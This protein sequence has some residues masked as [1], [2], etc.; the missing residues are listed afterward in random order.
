MT[1]PVHRFTFDTPD[2]ALLF[3]RQVFATCFDVVSFRDGCTVLVIDGHK[4]P[5]TERLL[6]LA[7]GLGSVPPGSPI[8]PPPLPFDRP[9]RVPTNPGDEAIDV[10]LVEV[11]DDWSDPTKPAKPED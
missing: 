2:R 8:P 7:R 11:D 10:D 4:P 6:S 3:V 5:Q 1:A 9:S